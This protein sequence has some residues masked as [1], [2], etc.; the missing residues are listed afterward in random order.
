L[1]TPAAFTTWSIRPKRLTVAATASATDC[2]LPTSSV[3][4]ELFL[5]RADLVRVRRPRHHLRA[6]LREPQR[7]RAADAAR[8]AG[9]ENDLA[10]NV[11]TLV[12]AHDFSRLNFSWT[13]ERA[14]EKSQP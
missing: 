13:A 10:G 2:S 4:A 3:T 11:E 14:E 9:D 6:R 7:D 8:A 1:I 5:D 12:D